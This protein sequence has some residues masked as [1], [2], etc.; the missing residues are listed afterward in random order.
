MEPI[1]Y[2]I[3]G[4][5]QN[6]MNQLMKVRAPRYQS[7][8]W[9]VSL[10]CILLPFMVFGKTLMVY[11]QAWLLG[12]SLMIFL[13]LQW[14]RQF[15][16]NKTFGRVYQDDV[17][18]GEGSIQLEERGFTIVNPD[19]GPVFRRFSQVASVS[20]EQ[21]VLV[22]VGRER[23]IEM[24]PLDNF[25]SGEPARLYN[26]MRERVP[27]RSSIVRRWFNRRD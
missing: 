24:V 22:I 13:G 2:L 12:S 21:Q 5:M 8:I 16:I 3:T 11:Q 27:L 15:Y 20:L 19:A 4:S 18:V 1:T 7:E 10:S 6:R 25:P 17:R 23:W 9:L 14:A 26:Y